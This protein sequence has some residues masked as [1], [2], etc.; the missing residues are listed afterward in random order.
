M[1][2]CDLAYGYKTVVTGIN[3]SVQAGEA[4]ALIGPNGSGK[5]TFLQA[6]IGIVR[7]SRG[8]LKMPKA[9]SIGYVP[10]Q[11]DLDLTFPITAR[12][13]VAMGLS[14]QT[15]FLGLLKKIRKKLLRMLLI[16]LVYSIAQMCDLVT[17][18]AVSA[19]AFFLRARLLQ[20]QRL[21]CS[22]NLLM[23]LMNR[24]AENFLIL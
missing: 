24:I 7:V 21:F 9:L 14:R 17:F 8:E 5:T 3:G 22:T 6:I 19:S 1:K 13:V 16:M 10:Q 18:L 11:V 2:N 4:L 15:G 20:S 12:Q 23:V